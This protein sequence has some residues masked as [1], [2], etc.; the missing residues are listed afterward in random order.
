MDNL[1]QTCDRFY[2]NLGTNLKI[3]L[4]SVT[5]GQTD[6]QTDDIMM[7]IASTIREL[8]WWVTDA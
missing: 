3:F 7:P 1:Q 6:G 5:D 2:D 8:R 4:S